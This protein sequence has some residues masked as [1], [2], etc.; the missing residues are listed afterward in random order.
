M[1]LVAEKTN[2]FYGKPVEDCTE[3]ELFCALMALCKERLGARPENRGERK[4]YYVSAEFLL[5]RLLAN[6]LLNLGRYE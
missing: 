2:A 1:A 3:E 6:N 5:G 4:L